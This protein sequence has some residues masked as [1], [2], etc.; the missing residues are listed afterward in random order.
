MEKTIVAATGNAHKLKEF[1]AILKG[2]SVLSAKEAGFFGDVEETGAT[3][4]QNAEL[5]ARAVCE[6]TGFAALAD[7][8]GLCVEALGGAPGV[9]SAR[10]SGGDDADNRGLLLKNMEG[11]ENRRAY[12]ACAI[13]LAFPDGEL[14]TAEGRTYGEIMREERG[15][16]GFGYDCL[17]FSE[18]LQK[19]FGE[20][21]D[22]EKNGVSHRG[23]ALSALEEKL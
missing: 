8:S 13:A 9:Y 18:D 15:T 3:F 12:F 1:R 6:A 11:V 22:E 17:F 23:R 10:Y 7:D 5:K 4:A 16:N 2:W 19:S 21:S 20:A 14:I